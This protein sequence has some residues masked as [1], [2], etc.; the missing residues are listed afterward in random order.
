MKLLGVLSNKRRLIYAICNYHLDKIVASLLICGSTLFFIISI[1]TNHQY[2]HFVIIGILAPTLY[3]ILREKKETRPQT[4]FFKKRLYL[5]L[6]IIFFVATLPVLYVFQLQNIH[7]IPTIYFFL[8]PILSFPIICQILY[9]DVTKKY[10][11]VLFEIIFLAVA[12][13]AIFYFGSTGYHGLDTWWHSEWIKQTI[14]LNHIT[15]GQYYVNQYSNI[16]LFHLLGA[17]SALIT[18]MPIRDTI[19]IVFGI[20]G[21]TIVS[22]LFIFVITKNFFRRNDVALASKLVFV[23][24]P[25]AIQNGFNIIPNSLGL[26]FFVVILYIILFIKK[27]RVFWWLLG[28]FIVSIALTHTLSSVVA[29]LMILFLIIGD[30][31][32]DKILNEKETVGKNKRMALPLLIMGLMALLS[33]VLDNYY[34]RGAQAY[35]NK[36]F[37][38]VRFNN[39]ESKQLAALNVPYINSILPYIFFFSLLFFAVF[40]GLFVLSKEYRNRQEFQTIF[41]LGGLYILFA[42][43]D[44]F[45]I[46]GPLSGRLIIFIMVPLSIFATAG[47]F[48]MASYFKNKKAIKQILVS[49]ILSVILISGIILPINET[50]PFLYTGYGSNRVSWTSVEIYSAKSLNPFE[51]GPVTTDH[52]YGNIIPHIVGVKDYK[53]IIKRNNS[54]FIL[55]WYYLNHPEW[56]NKYM[57]KIHTGQDFESAPGRIINIS[58]YYKKQ[59]IKNANIYNNSYVKIYLCEKNG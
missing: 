40:A 1:Y 17:I 11:I 31:L 58:Q 49:L 47:L 52:F 32:F 29:F 27:T 9:T 19:F 55:R 10:Q 26:T 15:D 4:C 57:S 16:P 7:Y 34:L 22:P 46:I 8:L 39:M 42:L 37:S 44:V 25:I 5:I 36:L 12:I 23:L 30:K 38:N 48:K 24:S 59:I 53:N 3:F 13:R 35:I 14:A 51:L 20:F 43:F 45:G 28:L 21:G 56:N 18:D 2:Y 54:A 41:L 6:S 33:V 50:A